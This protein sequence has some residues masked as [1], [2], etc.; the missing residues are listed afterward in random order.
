ML[1]QAIGLHLLCFDNNFKGFNNM[2]IEIHI[3]QLSICQAV[4]LTRMGPSLLALM[5]ADEMNKNFL[6]ALQHITKHLRSAKT[7]L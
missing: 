2:Y 4:V 7:V 1:F 5:S 6:P 3:T